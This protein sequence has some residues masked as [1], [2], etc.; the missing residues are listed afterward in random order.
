M[1]ELSIIL[2]NGK[3]FSTHCKARTLSGLLLIICSI[4]WH[5]P[6][7]AQRFIAFCTLH[8][9]PLCS[10]RLF[11]SKAF[12]FCRSLSD[13]KRWSGRAPRE[14]HCLP[15]EVYS[16]SSNGYWKEIQIFELSTLHRKRTM[17]V[18]FSMQSDDD[19]QS[20]CP[21]TSPQPTLVYCSDEETPELYDS[22]IR[23]I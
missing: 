12:S 5:I 13:P 23:H 18:L 17:M 22:D 3:T 8:A 10:N 2:S 14:S 16:H 21:S 4:S 19:R 7:S 20:L 15:D 11:S 1:K 6:V 9:G